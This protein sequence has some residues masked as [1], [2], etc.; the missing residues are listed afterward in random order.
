SHRGRRAPFRSTRTHVPGL[1]AGAGD[2]PARVRVDWSDHREQREESHMC[3]P[4]PWQAPP[5][6]SSALAVLL[7]L[8]CNPGPTSTA[9]PP[10]PP[11]AAPQGASSGAPGGQPGGAAGGPAPLIRT[12]SAYTSIVGSAMPWWVALE[13]GYFREQ[14]LDV[15]LLRVDPG[16][17]QVA[18][19]RN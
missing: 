13:A 18:A 3:R 16:A 14:G 2:S 15:E 7:L 17:P 10:P 12:R 9:P 19:M 5:L 1:C 8:A 11:A 6:A 4:S